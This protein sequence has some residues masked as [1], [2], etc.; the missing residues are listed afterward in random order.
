M[1]STVKNTHQIV[2]LDKGEI[3]EVPNHAE[4]IEQ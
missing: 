1:L 4:L 2:L 3:V